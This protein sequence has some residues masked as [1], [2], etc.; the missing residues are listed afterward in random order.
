L[1][2][3][4][5]KQAIGILPNAR[6][7]DVWHL[8]KLLEAHKEGDVVLFSSILSIAECTHAGGNMDDRVQNLFKRLLLSGEHLK[9]VQPTPYI[10]ADARDLRW[11]YNI[12]LG[13]ADGLHV[14]SAVD[15]K[16]SEF[17]T[18]DDRILKESSKIGQLGPNVVQPSK[19]NLLPDKYRQGNLLDDKVAKFKRSSP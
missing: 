10:A 2:L 7:S 16:C 18:V 15:R 9:L 14:S 1:I 8:W 12:N 5:A 3:D 4:A 17:L 11:K 19:T 13:G 6:N